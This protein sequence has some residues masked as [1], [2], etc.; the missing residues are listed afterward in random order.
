MEIKNRL[1]EIRSG[2]FEVKEIEAHRKRLEDRRMLTG[3][4]Y[5]QEKVRT[6]KSDRLAALAADIEEV[7]NLLLDRIEMIIA[8]EKQCLEV[9]DR[10]D[11]SEYRRLLF[12]RYVDDKPMSW[13]QIANA[14]HYSES[15]VKRKHEAALEEARTIWAGIQ[16]GTK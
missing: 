15:E 6:S 4:S 9:I 14:L 2:R 7:D 13:K 10:I 8:W 1:K 16:V 12:M 11:R 5:D 3:I